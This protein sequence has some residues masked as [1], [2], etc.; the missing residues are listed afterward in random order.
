MLLPSKNILLSLKELLISAVVIAIVNMNKRLCYV[1][2]F[3]NYFPNIFQSVSAN[4]LL[5]FIRMLK[6]R[7][8]KLVMYINLRLEKLKKGEIYGFWQKKF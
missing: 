5:A 1:I 8:E 3:Y 2:D 6:F 7:F 4:S